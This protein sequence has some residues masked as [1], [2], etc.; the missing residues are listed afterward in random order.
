MNLKVVNFKI[1]TLL[2]ESSRFLCR[3]EFVFITAC[4]VRL[5]AASVITYV[6]RYMHSILGALRYP[7]IKLF[8]IRNT[9]GGNISLHVGRP[10]E[11]DV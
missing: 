1:T 8:L 9:S 5:A 2:T 6:L 3:Y 4:F 7:N 11:L 10:L